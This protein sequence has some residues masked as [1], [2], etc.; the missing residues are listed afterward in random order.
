MKIESYF[1]DQYNWYFFRVSKI[2]KQAY[3]GDSIKKFLKESRLYLVG[4]EHG[5][6]GDNPH[7][8][9][10]VAYDEKKDLDT[11]KEEIKTFFEKANKKNCFL[12]AQDCNDRKSA[13]K[14]NLKE[15]DFVYKGFSKSFINDMIKCATKKEQFQKKMEKIEDQ[16]ILKEISWNKYME[17]YI[18]IKTE[19]GFPL[20]NSQIKSKFNCMLVRAKIQTPDEYIREFFPEYLR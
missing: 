8:Q 6:K 15:G 10:V 18:R 7:I 17:E 14:Y 9:G 20:N 4:Y 11:L 3:N 2:T 13:I 1:Q 12:Y 16:L 5:R 19:H